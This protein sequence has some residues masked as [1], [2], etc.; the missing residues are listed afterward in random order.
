[1][2]IADPALGMIVL[3]LGILLIIG[4]IV[5]AAVVYRESREWKKMIMPMFDLDYTSMVPESMKGLRDMIPFMNAFFKQ[6]F[7]KVFTYAD[8][9]GL[10]GGAGIAIVGVL[11]LLI[12][13]FLGG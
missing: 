13:V 12:G 10:L 2:P 11:V 1:M 3:I 9:V 7:T 6:I 5:I 8:V 4:G